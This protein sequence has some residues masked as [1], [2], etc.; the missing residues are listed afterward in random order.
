MKGRLD[1]VKRMNM[2]LCVCVGMLLI[3]VLLWGKYQ[4]AIGVVPND[5]RLLNLEQTIFPGNVFDRDGLLIA[6]GTDVNGTFSY[7]E[8]ESIRKSF[9]NIFGVSL[10][11]T[12]VSPFYLR[13]TLAV[14][15]YGYI[16]NRLTVDNLFTTQL[17]GSDVN[18]TLDMTLN[19]RIYKIL[20]GGNYSA[21]V[22]VY[23]YLTGEVLALVST[24]SYDLANES[25]W[26]LENGKISVSQNDSAGMNRV[27]QECYPPC[28]MIKPILYSI[29]LEQMPEM[30]NFCYECSASTE[31][32]GITITDHNPHG[33]MNLQSAI[34]QSCNT[35]AVQIGNMLT[36]EQFQRGLE[37]YGF[38]EGL[39]SDYITYYKGN[40]D[41]S[42]TANKV[43]A[44]L[45]Q[46]GTTKMSIL[47]LTKCYGA[48]FNNGIMMEPY[49]T[50]DVKSQNGEQV[51]SSQ[52]A[53]LILEGLKLATENGTA[54]AINLSFMGYTCAGKT[55]TGDLDGNN[56]IWCT[57]GFVDN[58][59]PYI[60]TVCLTGREI[61]DTGGDVCAPIVRQVLEMLLES[62]AN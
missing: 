5:T 36:A 34:A 59:M 62:N 35:Y 49:V 52:T 56:T 12:G 28:S 17:K 24:P 25:T 3:F 42:T 57:G 61:G 11:Q 10:T 19:G 60:V 38:Y 9:S 31:I 46:G 50:Q 41:M 30:A 14:D 4:K 23:N 27:M 43:F 15:L 55:G 1:E 54:G 21:G 53:Q 40:I 7:I 39:Y 33:T 29:I 6:K 20:E 37:S 18:L 58:A 45:G 22:C 16:T 32:D 47:Q 51:I 44:M 8:D 2:I 13:K 26:P 48:F